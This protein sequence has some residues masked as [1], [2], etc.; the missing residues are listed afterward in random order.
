MLL[1][2]ENTLIWQQIHGGFSAF[3]KSVTVHTCEMQFQNADKA[4][5]LCTFIN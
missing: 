2:K 4:I 5:D 1:K 3:E